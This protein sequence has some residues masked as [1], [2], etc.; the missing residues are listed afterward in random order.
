MDGD[1]WIATGVT[2]GGVRWQFQYNASSSSAYKWEFIGGPPVSI[3]GATQSTLTTSTWTVFSIGTWTAWRGGDYEFP[4]SGANGTYGTSIPNSTIELAIGENGSPGPAPAVRSYS[5]PPSTF[6]WQLAGMP[7]NANG[8]AAGTVLSLMGFV[9][10]AGYTFSF[11]AF[12][13]L[14][15]RIA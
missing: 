9:N 7:V 10:G 11:A 4:S 15:V 12:T 13:I 3:G 6:D 5:P 2:T 1:I 8:L 14:P